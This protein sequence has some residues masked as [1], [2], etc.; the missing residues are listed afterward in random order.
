M[1]LA[2]GEDDRFPNQ[3]ASLVLDTVIDQV[4][5]NDSVCFLT[6]DFPTYVF[7]G[8]SGVASLFFPKV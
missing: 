4:F 5:E 7:S 6:K 1:I 8:N 2:L 3:G